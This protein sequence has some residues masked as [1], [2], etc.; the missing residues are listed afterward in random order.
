MRSDVAE[1]LVSVIDDDDA[2]RTAL[3][4]LLR[5]CGYRVADF[6][7]AE[8][9]LASSARADSACIVSDIRLPGGMSGVELVDRLAALGDIPPI[10]LISATE[11]EVALGLDSRP[12]V[13]CFLRKPFESQRLIDCLNKALAA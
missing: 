4:S 10:I 12:G 5:S 1:L 9:F 2:V 8:A 11:D 13:F 3:D 7:S 6:A